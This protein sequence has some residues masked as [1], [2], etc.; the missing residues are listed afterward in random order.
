LNFIAD[1]NAPAA[2]NTFIRIPLEKGRTIIRRRRDLF[3]RIERF[4]H[5]IFIDQPLE[6]TFT[7]F[8][9]PGTDHGMVE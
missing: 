8:F 5:S 4:F 9:A 2:E 7:L 3:P 6:C 1:S